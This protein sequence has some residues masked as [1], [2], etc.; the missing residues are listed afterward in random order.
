M[1][2]NETC[3]DKTELE[4]MLTGTLPPNDQTRVSLHLED[5]SACQATFEQ[6]AGE[7]PWLPDRAA[8]TASEPESALLRLM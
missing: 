6:L 2:A 3:P 7:A 1:T 5:C 8:P 4:S